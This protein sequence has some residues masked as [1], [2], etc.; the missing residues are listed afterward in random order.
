MNFSYQPLFFVYLFSCALFY[1]CKL[2]SIIWQFELCEI[3]NNTHA[4]EHR[5]TQTHTQ[6]HRSNI[7]STAIEWY[8]WREKKNYHKT[9]IFKQMIHFHR[10]V[11]QIFDDGKIDL[12]LLLWFFLFLFYFVDWFSETCFS[13]HGQFAI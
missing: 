11:W 13:S 5:R 12:L 10:Y 2:D 7:K 6:T 4:H 9:K 3:D 1:R 8:N